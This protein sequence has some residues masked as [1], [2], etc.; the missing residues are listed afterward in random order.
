MS[1]PTD[2]P[3]AIPVPLIEIVS[4]PAYKNWSVVTAGADALP[5][6]SL[7]CAKPLGTNPATVRAAPA[8]SASK[9]N[10]K[11]FPRATVF[12][13]P[14]RSSPRRDA[15]ARSR[16]VEGRP[17]SEQRANAVSRAY[18]TLT[19]CDLETLE[20]RL[21]IQYNQIRRAPSWARVLRPRGGSYY[22]APG[23]RP[24]RR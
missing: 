14:S 22:E 15:R 9:I 12:A 19:R 4:P 17:R 24:R 6:P 10:R 1:M 8:T 7:T 3:G 2:S 13:L 16:S 18:V 21:N 23:A 20:R 11:V 5:P